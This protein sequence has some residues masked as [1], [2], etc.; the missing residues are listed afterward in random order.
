MDKLFN[1]FVSRVV[2]KTYQHP[3]ETRVMVLITLIQPIKGFLRGCF[4]SLTF[5]GLWYKFDSFWLL[6]GIYVFLF[7]W[8]LITQITIKKR[9][10]E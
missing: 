3:D 7:L 8:I 2:K 5:L 1:F 9:F 6:V 4:T 10:F